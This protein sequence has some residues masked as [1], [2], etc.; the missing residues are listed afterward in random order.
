MTV[1]TLPRQVVAGTDAAALDAIARPEVALVL[2]SRGLDPALRDALDG[3]D[4]ATIDDVRLDCRAGD[5]VDGDLRAA[6]Y[7]DM[8]ADVLGR[9]IAMLV[10]RH[11]ALTGEDR[12]RVRLDVIDTDACRRFH[13][14]YVTLRL[15]CT[16]AGPGTQWCDADE[17]EAVRDVATGSV[18]VFKGRLLLDP[19]SVLHRSPPIAATGGRRLM[20]VIDPCPVVP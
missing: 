6:G 10:A 5:A 20:L 1:T 3:L 2:W 16:Y 13:A 15:L 7:G 17:P 14:D 9:D 19:P 18:G 8:L 12:L 11:A 4:Y